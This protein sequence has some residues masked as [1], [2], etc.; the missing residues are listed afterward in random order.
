MAQI[1]CRV[2]DETKNKAQRV[3]DDIG[4][5]MSSAITIFLKRVA[6]DNAIPFKLVGKSQAET[7]NAETIEELGTHSDL[8]NK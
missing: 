7:P 8:F 3:F 4:I 5:S 6:N 2:D 1:N